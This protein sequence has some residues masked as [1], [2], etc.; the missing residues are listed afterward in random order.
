MHTQTRLGATRPRNDH[1][2]VWAKQLTLWQQWREVARN[3][4]A[5]ELSVA[6]G[7]MLT[8]GCLA[9]IFGLCA[10]LYAILGVS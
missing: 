1:H 2:T 8:A 7:A 9:L 10:G 3:R 6:K 5:G 4:P